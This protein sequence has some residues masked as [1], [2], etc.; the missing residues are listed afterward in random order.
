MAIDNFNF[1]L[2]VSRTLKTPGHDRG[3][4]PLRHSEED[5]EREH[6]EVEGAGSGSGS[7]N[8][9]SGRGVNTQSVIGE[10]YAEFADRRQKDKVSAWMWLQQALARKAGVLSPIAV[11][12]KDLT[13]TLED[14][15]IMLKGQQ[16]ESGE[17]PTEYLEK[18]LTTPG[19]TQ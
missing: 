11:S 7:G 6:A 12:L 2:R 3:P 15:E 8:A 1:P 13:A 14:I 4:D 17:T 10:I 9:F 19:T 5:S 16:G 18:F